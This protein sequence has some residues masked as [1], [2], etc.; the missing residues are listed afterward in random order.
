MTDSFIF[1]FWN[2]FKRSDAQSKIYIIDYSF[3]RTFLKY[4]CYLHFLSSNL[5]AIHYI[6]NEI[7]Y[8]TWRI[9]LEAVQ[10]GFELW[11]CPGNM[12][13]SRS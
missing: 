6:N 8:F 1:L 4:A 11:V 2:A 3:A 7:I 12:S 13:G 9:A 5:D 10:I